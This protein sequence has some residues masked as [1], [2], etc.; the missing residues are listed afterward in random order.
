MSM[1]RAFG[2]LVMAAV[3]GCGGDDTVADGTTCNT[4]WDC[5]N[6]VCECADGGSCADDADCEVKCEVCE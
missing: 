1:M 6:D 2:F 4:E 3:V 5:I